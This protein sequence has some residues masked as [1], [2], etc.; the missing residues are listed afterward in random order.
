MSRKH[1]RSPGT[2]GVLPVRKSHT[3][4]D[5]LNRSNVHP[6]YHLL[7]WIVLLGVGALLFVQSYQAWGDLIIDLGRDLYLP[8]QLLDGRVLYRD[9]LY[10]YGP[11]APYLLAGVVALFGDNLQVFSSVGILSGLSCMAALYLAG[12]RL[13][14]ILAGFSTALFFLVCSFFANSTWGCNFVLPYSYA[15]TF[16]MSFALWSFYFL[17]RYLF[18]GRQ[19]RALAFGIAFL[20]LAAFSKQEIAIAIVGVYLLAWYLYGFP[21]R[22]TIAA[23]IVAAAAVATAAAVFGARGGADHSLLGEN[24][25]PAKFSGG[26]GDAFFLA[27]AGLDQPWVRLGSILRGLLTLAAVVW[28]ALLAHSIPGAYKNGKY[29]R[30]IT[31]AVAIPAAALALWYVADVHL[32]AVFAPIG[33]ALLAVLVAR[34]QW[35]DP[36]L[37]VSAFVLLSALRIPLG[38]EPL[39]YGFYLCAPV[40]LF[41]VY[42]LAV[43]LP[44][45]LPAPKVTTAALAV[46]AALVLVRFEFAM[47][48]GFEPGG[49]YRDMTSRLAT[50]KGVMRDAATGRAEAIGQFLDYMT[51]TG[52]GDTASGMVV[53]P[54]GLTLN[55]FAGIRNPTAYYL[56]IPPEMQ[57]PSVEERMIAELAATRPRY[58]VWNARD[59]REY[60]AAQIGQDYAKAMWNW[61]AQNYQI[62]KEFPTDPKPG[63]PA[64]KIVLLRHKDGS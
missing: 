25:N 2:R 51:R 16:G 19:P 62:E 49:G 43:R 55:Y 3:S 13:G 58:V 36:I 47:W 8:G 27:V 21:R 33:A 22:A 1:R 52:G 7:A 4:A 39:W 30:A 20:F 63:D 50:A 6:A 60:G 17:L 15:A 18:W 9:V 42:G 54:E 61:L 29:A 53:I 45:M 48:Y 38:D 10:N 44:R 26:A 28:A 57:P 64:Y 35:D 56:F 34:R 37:L 46:V 11:V 12:W 24:L 23:G 14:G 31:A 5:L 41:A 40:Y 59:V 32:L